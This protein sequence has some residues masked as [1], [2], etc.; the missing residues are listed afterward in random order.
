MFFKLCLQN[1]Q[2]SVSWASYENSPDNSP[3]RQSPLKDT[4]EPMND[5]YQFDDDAMADS[6]S[7]KKELFYLREETNVLMKDIEVCQTDQEKLTAENNQLEVKITQKTKCLKKKYKERKNT[8]QMRS[9]ID[10][11]EVI[12]NVETNYESKV[13]DL[14]NK[15]LDLE[16]SLELMRHEFEEMENYWQKKIEDERSFYDTQIKIE[17]GHFRDLELKILEYDQRFSMEKGKN[18]FTIQEDE[19]LESEVTILE[20]ELEELKEQMTY[21]TEENK[22]LRS[23][24]F[25]EKQKFMISDNR[26][27]KSLPCPFVYW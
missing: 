8:E 4:K 14:S 26:E 22:N 13:K 12:R 17:E 24:I 5:N 20:E 21:L 1:I 9:Y 15:N 27:P 2:I 16:E 3:E 10:F 19:R 6:Q 23:Q 7:L 18:L 11:E 25:E